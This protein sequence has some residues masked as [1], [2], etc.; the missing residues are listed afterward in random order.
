MGSLA[1]PQ[2]IE[3]KFLGFEDGR[4]F[5]PWVINFS[6]AW[7]ADSPSYDLILSDPVLFMLSLSKK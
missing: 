3:R 4:L 1:T 7:L 6:L 2:A 5:S